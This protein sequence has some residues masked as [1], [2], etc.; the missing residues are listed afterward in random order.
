MDVSAL[1]VPVIR[2][3]ITRVGTERKRPALGNLRIGVLREF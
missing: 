1:E 2:R 3:Q